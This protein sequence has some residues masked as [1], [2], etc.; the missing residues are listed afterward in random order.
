MQGYVS[1]P[2]YCDGSEGQK[3]NT[4]PI[5]VDNLCIKGGRFGHEGNILVDSKPVCDDNWGLEDAAVVCRQLG[6]P[7]VE[8]ATVESQFGSIGADY[9][10]ENVGCL[11]NE[12]KLSECPHKKQDTCFSHEAAGVICATQ[13][14][15][16]PKDCLKKGKICLV[17]GN[18]AASGNVYVGGQPLCH[19]GW[20]YADANVV[21]RCLGYI[22][23]SDFTIK[24]F[25]GLT[26]TYFQLTDVDCRGDEASLQECPKSYNVRSCNTHSV[27][28]VHCIPLMAK[29]VTKTH[30][31]M[32]IIGL[33]IALAITVSILFLVLLYM[34][35]DRFISLKVK[36]ESLELPSKTNIIR[37]KTR[38]SVEDLVGADFNQ[39][40]NRQNSAPESETENR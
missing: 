2:K 32:A 14:A 8:A 34:H 15:G 23:A 24:S 22:G 7:G 33:T 16:V 27:A 40:Y 18:S 10:M 30:H 20:D 21:C 19:N 36:V 28:G 12:T 6:F 11:G 3:N 35:R 1:G 17:G 4:Q 31:E 29:H 26:D 39:I 37:L 5:C 38:H 9:A 13:S 25:F